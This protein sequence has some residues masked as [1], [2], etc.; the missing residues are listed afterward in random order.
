MSK[1]T[2]NLDDVLDQVKGKAEGDEEEVRPLEEQY[3]QLLLA[4][5][6]LLTVGQ[7]Y[8]PGHDRYKEVVQEAFQALRVA[9]GPRRSLPVEVAK[10]GFWVEGGFL[11]KE[12]REGR[13]LHEMFDPLNIAEIEFHQDVTPEELHHGMGV[14]KQN[15][16]NLSAADS[17]KEMTIHGMPDTVVV[18]DRSLYVRTRGRGRGPAG[19]RHGTLQRGPGRLPRRARRSG[20]RRRPDRGRTHRGGKRCALPGHSP[21]RRDLSRKDR[22]AIPVPPGRSPLRVPICNLQPEF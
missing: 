8:Q 14:L 4:L 16:A 12:A 18:T 3:V 20:R 19:V 15:L 10:D 5:D 6:R 2:M 17:Y 21:G 11:E 13:R 22:Q 9:L 1:N 7:Y